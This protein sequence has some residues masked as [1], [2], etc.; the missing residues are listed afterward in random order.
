MRQLCG[1]CPPFIAATVKL[2]KPQMPTWGS[3]LDA[4][5]AYCTCVVCCAYMVYCIYCTRY[6]PSNAYVYIVRLYMVCCFLPRSTDGRYDAISKVSPTLCCSLLE[7]PAFCLHH[8]LT[9]A[10]HILN[11]LT[12]VRARDCQ[13]CEFQAMLVLSTGLTLIL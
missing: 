4:G 7:I 8:C 13:C 9:S 6:W 5:C 2:P 10:L 11:C 3:S 1:N 12:D